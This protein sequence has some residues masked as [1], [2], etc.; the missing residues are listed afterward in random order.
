M[1]GYLKKSYSTGMFNVAGSAVISAI[2][3]PLIVQKI[4]LELY[5]KWA[6][7]FLIAGFSNIAD[8]GISKSLVYLI[9]KQNNQHDSNKIYSAALIMNNLSVLT[10]AIICTTIYLLGINIWQAEQA[11]SIET[12]NKLFIYGSFI[13][14]CSLLTQFCRSILEAFYKIYIVNIGF[15]LLTLLNYIPI[16]LL[17]IYTDDINKLIYCTVIIN[18]IILFFHIIAVNF[19]CKVSF[20][21]PPIK[22]FKNI[23]SCS[24]KF[25]SIGLLI[26]AILPIN[27][28]LLVYL[29]D[30]TKIYGA[31]DISIKIAMMANSCLAL[32][33]TP[34]LSLFSGYGKERLNEIK[35]ILKRSLIGLGGA[36]LLGCFTFFVT[37]KSVLQWLFKIDTGEVFI[38]SLILIIGMC[39]TGVSEPFYRAFLGLGNL[40]FPFVIKTTLIVLNVCIIALLFNINPLHRISLAIAISY[41]LTSLVTI[42]A[43]KVKFY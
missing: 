24:I 39:L 29:S 19:L 3:I 10:V 31:F 34:L 30:D 1:T 32:F 18:I 40:R 28:Y 15:L 25:L 42:A 5:G 4:G 6:L 37:G 43:F 33:A 14:C 13:A 35:S 7:L 11:F 36:Y 8:F 9:P 21:I 20:I 17:T 16:Y 12:G 38:S 23:F 22:I 26:S 2:F 27:R 41:G